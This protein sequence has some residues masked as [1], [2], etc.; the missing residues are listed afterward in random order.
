MKA[1]IGQRIRKLRESKDFS[2][3]NM[4]VELKLTTSAYSKIERGVTDVQASRLMRIAEILGVHV[5]E[6][7]PDPPL[8][9]GAIGPVRDYGFATK[10]DIYEV[11]Q[12]IKMMQC[13]IERIRKALR[14]LEI[15]DKKRVKKK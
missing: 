4:A 3:E 15:P 6:F 11:M 7:F 13:D 12:L 9:A 2:Q 5:T 10:G 1:S 14:P 8:T